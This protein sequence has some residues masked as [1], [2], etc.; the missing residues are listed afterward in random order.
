[1]ICADIPIA[2]P[3]KESADYEIWYAITQPRVKGSL[4]LNAATKKWE[5][6]RNRKVSR[7]LFLNQFTLSYQAGA[8]YAMLNV[9][10]VCLSLEERFFWL[11]FRHSTLGDFIVKVIKDLLRSKNLQ[12][13][14]L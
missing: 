2:P 12:F 10:I 4:G 3:Y 11:L 5:E 8:K 9:S 7:R 14:F 13:C 6:I 1:M